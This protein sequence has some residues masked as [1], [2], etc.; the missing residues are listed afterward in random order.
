MRGAVARSLLIHALLAIGLLLMMTGVALAN[1]G[2]G[3]SGGGSS[4]ISGETLNAGQYDLTFRLDFTDFEN[5]SEAEVIA[6]VGQGGDHFDALAR[7][8]LTTASLSYGVTDDLEVSG[9]IGYYYGQDFISAHTHEHHEGEEEEPPLV[10][11]ADPNGLTDLWVTAKY[12]IMKGG[13]GHLSLIGGV[14]FPTGRDDVDDSNNHALEPSSQPGSGA[15]DF[16]AGAAYSRYLTERITIDA[17]GVYTFRLEHDD[18]KVGDRAD[19]GVALA[20]RLMEDIT[21]FPSVSVF[22]EA[23]WV[24]LDH[25]EEAG[26]DNPNSGGIYL[27][28][29]PGVRV[30]W[31]NT[32]SMAVAPA[33]PV[34]QDLEGEQVETDYKLTFSLSFVF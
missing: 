21:S 18:F 5:V 4:T 19:V 29:S 34:V 25:D 28:L 32:F 2:P 13:P 23:L 30:R 27:Y 15:F 1:H 7:S 11:T 16:Q 20:Y 31:N 33:F 26:V 12:R 22:G 6:Q 24:W 8:Y 3:T 10:G 17:S 9:A 14:K